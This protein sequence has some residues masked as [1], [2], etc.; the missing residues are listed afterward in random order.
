MGS[1]NYLFDSISRNRFGIE[2][3]DYCGKPQSAEIHRMDNRDITCSGSRTAIL[4]FLRARQP[5]TENHLQ[6]H[7]QA[8]NEKT[9]QDKITTREAGRTGGIQTNRHTYKQ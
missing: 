2:F 8:N 3:G 9:S 4:L 1:G 6:T 7:L 5:Q